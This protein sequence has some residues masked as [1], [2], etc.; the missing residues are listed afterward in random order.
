MFDKERWDEIFEN[1][2]R[3]KLRTGLTA[4]SV[5]WGIFMLVILLGTGQGMENGIRTSFQKDAI[6]SINVYGGKT[7]IPSKG[8]QVGRPIQFDNQDFDRLSSDRS[9]IEYASARYRIPTATIINYQNESGSFEVKSVH[10]ENQFIELVTPMQGRFL[11]EIDITERRKVVALGL[12]L[13]KA[14]FVNNE[15][16]IGKTIQINTVPFLVV[17]ILDDGDTESETETAYI[18]ISTAQLVFNGGTRV[19]QVAVT[20]RNASLEQSE[21]VGADIRKKLAERY[22]FDPEDKQAVFVRNNFVEYNRIIS[23]FDGI[24]MFVWIIGI[25]T[26]TAGVVGVSNIM[27]IV[28]KERTREI[29]IRKALGAT[30]FSIISLIVQEAVF[31]TTVSGYIGLVLGVGLLQLIQNNVSSDF[32]KNPEIDLKIALSSTI[33]LIVAGAFAGFFPARNAAKIQPIEALRYE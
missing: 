3:N 1:L 26:I 24:R 10:P 25:G 23:L 11:N 17:G 8:M 9:Q 6:N 16:P 27:M 22:N 2:N 18:P 21:I 31:I 20:L 5:A 32:F 13:S 12:K 15:D 33:L 19:N 30:P 4:F 29:G 7:S 14:L 28:V